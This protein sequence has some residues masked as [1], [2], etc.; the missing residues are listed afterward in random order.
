[1]EQNKGFRSEE[2]DSGFEHGRRSR[3]NICRYDNP[4][5]CID[6]L[7]FHHKHGQSALSQ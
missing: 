7:L 4:V 2:P 1:M 6:R 5:A 3:G